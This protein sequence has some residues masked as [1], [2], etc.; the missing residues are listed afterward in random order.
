[1]CWQLHADL[2]YADCAAAA[3]AAAAHAHALLQSLRILRLQDNRLTGSLPP[4]LISY[5]VHMTGLDLS[6]NRLSGAMPGKALASLTSLDY[7]FITNSRPGLS[8]AL[9]PELGNLKNM[10]WLALYGNN[11]TGSLPRQWSGMTSITV[12][13]VGGYLNGRCTGNRL[14]GTLPAEYSSMTRMIRFEAGCNQLTGT[15]PAAF[16][17]WTKL[18]AFVVCENKLN[19]TLPASYAR[20]GELSA[21]RLNNNSFSG[22]VPAQWSAMTKLKEVRL[23]ANAGLQGCIPRSWQPQ[24]NLPSSAWLQSWLWSDTKVAGFCPK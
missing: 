7:F 23:Y 3:A 18:Q 22:P 19:G 1:M 21:I 2:P 4:Q 8:G 15:L 9:P 24:V 10:T 20:W 14:S 12:L 6:R 16:N 5:W 13:D 17:S 11:F